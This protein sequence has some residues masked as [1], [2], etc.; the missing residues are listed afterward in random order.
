MKIEIPPII[1]KDWLVKDFREGKHL[2]NLELSRYDT[3]VFLHL[4]VYIV[5]DGLLESVN[6]FV[7]VIISNIISLATNSLYSLP[8][9]FIKQI[10]NFI[11][12]NVIEIGKSCNKLFNSRLLRT[13]SLT[14]EYFK[15]CCVVQALTDNFTV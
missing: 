3:V 6:P 11:I 7:K 5:G 15:L 12:V 9:Q 8:C 14:V 4:T 10:G 2:A 13:P 1:Y